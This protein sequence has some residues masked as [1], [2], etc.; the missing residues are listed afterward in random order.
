MNRQAGELR[1]SLPRA[2]VQRLCNGLLCIWCGPLTV[3][4]PQVWS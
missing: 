4:G 3:L 1:D 2:A